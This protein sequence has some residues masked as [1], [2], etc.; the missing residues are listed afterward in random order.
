MLYSQR[1]RTA[2]ISNSQQ[3]KRNKNW[4]FE[5]FLGVYAENML[6][7]EMKC[8]YDQN[9]ILNV[10]EWDKIKNRLGGSK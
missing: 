9:K 6:D 5:I 3:L 2:A 8:M 4:K 1:H 7:Y 10:L